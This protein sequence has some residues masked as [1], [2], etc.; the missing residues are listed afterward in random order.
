MFNYWELVGICCIRNDEF[1]VFM[2]SKDEIKIKIVCFLGDFKIIQEIQYD[3]NYQLFYVFG[4]YYVF[5][6]EN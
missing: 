4:K 1:L 5:V 2:E 6:E 3:E